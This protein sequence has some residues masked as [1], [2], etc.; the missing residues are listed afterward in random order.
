MVNCLFK[1]IAASHG[2]ACDSMGFL[3]YLFDLNSISANDVVC[4]VLI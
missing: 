1:L 4:C 2:S 3:L